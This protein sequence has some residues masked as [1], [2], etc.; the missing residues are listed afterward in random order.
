MRAA[1]IAI[2]SSVIAACCAGAAEPRPDA[3][4]FVP[5]FNGKDISGWVERHK[6]GYAVEDGG[7]VWEIDQFLDRELFLAEVELDDPADEVVLP[8]W[9][10][11]HVV[12]EVTGDGDYVN[13]N[14][15]K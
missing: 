4:G 15:A 2:V 7:V 12:R 3:E 8:G 5:L 9:L 14:L 6:G 10:A 1:C 11:D 13:L